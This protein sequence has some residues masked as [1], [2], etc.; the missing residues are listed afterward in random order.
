MLETRYFISLTAWHCRQHLFA[1]PYDLVTLAQPRALPLATLLP[2]ASLSAEWQVHNLRLRHIR[3]PYYISCKQPIWPLPVKH[4]QTLLTSSQADSCLGR[5]D[6]DI[7]FTSGS[8]AR[9]CLI[10]ESYNTATDGIGC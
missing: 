7:C 10:H 5:P 2:N 4:A 9:V 1:A 6:M 3:H 8:S